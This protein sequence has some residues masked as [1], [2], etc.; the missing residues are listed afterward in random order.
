VI[1]RIGAYLIEETLGQG[2]MGVVYKGFHEELKR[3]A[4]IKTLSPGKSTSPE[5]QARVASEAQAQARLQHPNLATVYGLIDDHGE[6]FIA[7]EYVEGETLDFLLRKNNERNLRFTL[8]EAMGLFEQSLAALE[9]VH[10]HGVVHRDIKPANVMVSGSQLKLLDFGIA[11]LKDIAHQTSS[12]IALGNPEYMSPEQAQF[13]DVYLRADIYSAAAVLFE[14]LSGRRLFPG[15]EGLDQLRCHLTE[16]PSALKT[17]VPGLPAGVSDAV[18]IA[19]EKDPKLR[20]QTAGD[21]LRALQEGLAGFLP[22]PPTPVAE[23]P[24][25][26]I[27]TSAETPAL[28]AAARLPQ[29]QRNQPLWHPAAFLALLILGVGLAFGLWKAWYRPSPLH[30]TDSSFVAATP[31]QPEP[32][33]S[34]APSPTPPTQ[35]APPQETPPIAPPPKKPRPTK[36][37]AVVAVEAKPDPAEVRRQ[38][39][40]KLR[41]EVREGIKG[42]RADLAA[43][44][45]DSAQEKLDLLMGET[46]KFPTELQPESEEI[47]SLRKQVNEALVAKQTKEREGE[48]QQAAWETRLQQ[49][50][51]LIAQGSFPEAEKLARDLSQEQ[52]VPESVSA[53]ARQL[54]SQAKDEI[55]KAFEGTTL[56]PTKNKLR[57]PPGYGGYKEGS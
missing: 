53:R 30:Q 42:A 10:Q 24:K 27:A 2:G 23:S 16:I 21:F 41:E 18:A 36:V 7:M 11:S 17:L 15:K 29:P 31:V 49:I 6:L 3:Y 40:E 51:S 14:M 5:V 33:Q 35:G 38:E 19:L 22:I 45:F 4:A 54:R 48:L 47:R 12:G 1:E 44:S 32:S 9:Y 34:P 43:Q 46:R 52:S 26:V 13:Q 56:G 55:K 25:E 20:F 57:K 50:Q 39:T 37:I 8:S 28:A